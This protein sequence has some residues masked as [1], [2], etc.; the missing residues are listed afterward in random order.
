MKLTKC[1]KIRVILFVFLAAI[2]L[3]GDSAHADFTFGE[4]VNFGPTINTPYV[5]GPTCISPDGLE[6]YIFSDRPG[7]LGGL[8]LWVMTRTT[9]EDDWELPVNLGSGVN[10]SGYE[11]DACISSDGLE[12]Y[13]DAYQ[14]SGGHGGWDNWV[15]RR[16]TRNDS[17][18]LAVNLGPPLNTSSGDNSP[19]TSADGLEFYFGS[20]RPG[21]QGSDD[22]WVAKRSTTN[23]SWG[24]PVNLGA[25]INSSAYECG[26]KISSDSLM[27]FFSGEIHSP[28]RSGGF[29]L[30]DI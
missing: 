16:Q 8:D 2:V 5:E 22:L 27:L 20:S 14:R 24:E 1:V 7:S 28:Y 29:G 4:P 18:G 6:L 17:W 21:G 25:I 3:E 13:F 10:S 26:V 15:S 19:S 9:R 30:S 23:D 11:C 12:L